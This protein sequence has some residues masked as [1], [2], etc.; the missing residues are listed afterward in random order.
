MGKGKEVFTPSGAPNV[1]DALLIGN[2]FTGSIHGF[3]FA[4]F[5]V[6]GVYDPD[7]NCHCKDDVPFEWAKFELLDEQGNQV[8]KDYLGNWLGTDAVGA[9]S[10]YASSAVDGLFW[11]ENLKPGKYTLRERLDLIDR[12]DFDRDGLPDFT[13][14]NNTACSKRTETAFRTSKKA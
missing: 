2:F 14:Q 3:K 12:N 13:D 11:I 4:D 7:T 5:D 1:N 6:D 10:P 9:G 8:A